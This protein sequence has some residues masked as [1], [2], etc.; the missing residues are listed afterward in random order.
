MKFNICSLIHY[1]SY[2][3]AVMSRVECHLVVRSVFYLEQIIQESAKGTFLNQIAL[4][5][6]IYFIG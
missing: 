5:E 4:E 1:T 6:E 3:L 2:I